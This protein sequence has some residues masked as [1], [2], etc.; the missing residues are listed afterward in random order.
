MPYTLKYKVLNTHLA[1]KINGSRVPGKE[2]E[3]GVSRWSKVAQICEKEG[4]DHILVI[5]DLNGKFSL[6][7]AFKLVE[8]ADAIGWHKQY[9]LAIVA[10]TEELFLSLSFTETAMVNQGYEMKL[11]RK[12]REAKR[13]LLPGYPFFIKPFI[14]QIKKRIILF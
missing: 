13:W 9:K 6:D 12:K 14:S 3:E 8:S 2:V 7:S 1:V 10:A 5:M 4:H 11:F